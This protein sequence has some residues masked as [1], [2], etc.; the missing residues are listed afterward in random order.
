MNPIECKH[1]FK[2]EDVSN[3]REGVV[4]DRP[5]KDESCWVEIGL[6]KVNFSN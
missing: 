5:T 6:K 3:F 2:V 4:V 1:H